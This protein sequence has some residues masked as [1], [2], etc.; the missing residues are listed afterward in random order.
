M[1]VDDITAALKQ[2]LLQR[3]AET[4]TTLRGLKSVILNAEVA[5][6]KRDTGLDNDEVIALLQK[7]AKKRQEAAAIY[8]D[9]GDEARATKELSEKEIIAKFL[10]E[11]L[12][13]DAIV[14]LVESAITE[15][16]AST[17]QDMGKVIGAVKAKA[18]ATADGGVIARIV[19]EKLA[20]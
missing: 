12:D 1:V 19:K 11:Q 3:D 17:M 8:A 2:A 14:Q 4:A 9:A 18:G 5:A 20:V 15:L 6:G 10:P 7:E 13:E 16:G